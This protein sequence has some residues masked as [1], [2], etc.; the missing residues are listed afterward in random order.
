MSA[1]DQASIVINRC[2][3]I[4]ALVDTYVEKQTAATR[5]DLRR[6]LLDEFKAPAI[7]PPVAAVSVDT[8]FDALLTACENAYRIRPYHDFI[9]SLNAIRAC[10]ALQRQEQLSTVIAADQAHQRAEKAEADL[11]Q[12]NE[13]RAAALAENMQSGERWAQRVAALEAQ[14]ARRG[15]PLLPEAQQSTVID[16]AAGSEP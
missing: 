5:T 1:Y 6:A 11:N 2:K 3:R 16:V 10:A 4:L 14:L 13:W 8:D 15:A 9:S 7:A 12:I